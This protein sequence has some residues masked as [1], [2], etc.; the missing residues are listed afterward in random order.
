MAGEGFGRSARRGAGALLVVAAALLGVGPVPHAGNSA[1]DTSALAGTAAGSTA[2]AAPAPLTNPERNAVPDGGRAKA[3]VPKDEAT[4]VWDLPPG[5]LVLNPASG[6]KEVI[7]PDISSLAVL[8]GD[9]QSA[10]A[11]GVPS[12][13][14]WVVLGLAARGY[15]VRFMGAGGTGF[16]AKTSQAANYPDSLESGKTILPHGNPALVVVQGGGNDASTGA[17]D[18]AILA[19]AGRL[20]RDLKASYPKSGFLFIGTLARGSQSGGSRVHVDSLLAGF[21]RRNGIDF[22]SPADWITRY[23]VAGKMADR[24]HLTESGHRDLAK[25]L[26]ERLKELKLQGPGLG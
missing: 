25:V 18:A 6:R 16:T 9:S 3:P 8:I 23:G 14:T 12:Q 17:S 13:D 2:R 11:W 7:D 1:T 19:N 24:V 26:S 4:T 21:A 15:K 10:G 5:S 20:L 22:V